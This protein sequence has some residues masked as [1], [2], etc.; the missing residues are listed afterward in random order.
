MKSKVKLVDLARA[1]NISTTT[2]SKALN[3]KSDISAKTKKTV[4]ELAEKWDYRP[5]NLAIS[6]RKKRHLN[7]IG[8]VL[9]N[10]DH[11]FFSTILKGIISKASTEN[12]LVLVGESNQNA[13]KEK[14]ILDDFI[15]YGI[16]GVLIAP[17]PDS[18]Y[19]NLTAI[20]T[21]RIPHILI[22]RTFEGFEGH[23]VRSDDYNGAF[24]A[25]SHLMDQGYTKIAHVKVVDNW[26]VGSDRLKGYEDALKERGYEIRPEYIK[27][28]DLATK[29]E[30]LDIAAQL[31]T[32]SDPPDAIF[33]VND[34]V[35]SGIL[36]YSKNHNIHIPNELGLVGF[37]NSVISSMVS[38]KLTTVEQRGEAMGELAFDYFFQSLSNK[39]D[40]YQKTFESKLIVRES[41]IRL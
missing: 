25:V 18:N 22:D 13:E 26:S 28:C 4:L 37:S 32:A 7:L 40:V 35:A 20:T 2:V 11:Y 14:M 24:K 33:A 16:N 34:R 21:F 3:N 31:L 8:V 27:T 10:V 15:N 9:P 17:S 41:S 23:Y 1:L 30:G 19:D 6:L 5:N 38:P 39:D 12:Y 36:E 29:K